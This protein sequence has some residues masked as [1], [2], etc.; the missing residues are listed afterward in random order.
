VIPLD[1]KKC[2]TGHHL[3]AHKSSP[4][5]QT[6]LIRLWMEPHEG[7]NY[8]SI[9][10]IQSESPK[11]HVFT[12]IVWEFK[13]LSHTTLLQKMKH[14]SSLMCTQVITKKIRQF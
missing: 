1:C 9:Q 14:K 11:K 13:K 5:N 12:V 4:T 2:S 3:C 7:N 8:K 6:C 10:I